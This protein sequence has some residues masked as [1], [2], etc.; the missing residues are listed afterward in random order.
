M[1]ARFDLSGRGTTER[2]P[3]S[4]PAAT[5]VLNRSIT[6]KGH[7]VLNESVGLRASQPRPAVHCNGSGNPPHFGRCFAPA[8][9]SRFLTLAD[10]LLQGVEREVAPEGAERPAGRTIRRRNP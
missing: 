10:H 9:F 2:L 8:G 5:F 3:H 7:G 6:D 1:N 4:R